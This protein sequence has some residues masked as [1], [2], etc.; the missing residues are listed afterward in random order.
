MHATAYSLDITVQHEALLLLLQILL[1]ALPNLRAVALVAMSGSMVIDPEQMT[2]EEWEEHKRKRN[3]K[4]VASLE[5]MKR[6]KDYQ[7]VLLMLDHPHLQPNSSPPSTPKNFDDFSKRRWEGA[8]KRFR[9][10]VKEWAA[11]HSEIANKDK[12]SLHHPATEKSNCSIA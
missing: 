3:L 11:H 5:R 4:R 1:E 8:C 12:T 7:T 2:P 9:M 10:R 6:Q